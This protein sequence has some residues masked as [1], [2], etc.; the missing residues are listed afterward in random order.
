MPSFLTPDISGTRG[1]SRPSFC[2]FSIMA[3]LM[4]SSCNQNSSPQAAQPNLG[5]DPQESKRPIGRTTVNILRDI[6]NNNGGLIVPDHRALVVL[7][8]FKSDPPEWPIASPS[9]LLN[10]ISSSAL[11][12]RTA[13]PWGKHD[14][15]GWQTY[16]MGGAT[17]TPFFISSNAKGQC[18]TVATDNLLGPW[19]NMLS[20]V[21]HAE[22]KDVYAMFDLPS[23]LTPYLPRLAQALANQAS[24]DAQRRVV[25]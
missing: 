19:D 12:S 11:Y 22:D 10:D 5:T 4:T 13:S 2:M 23:A 21:V 25:Q 1:F 17:A 9:R 6:S 16:V 24:I 18:R 8:L 3:A 14:S 20:C 7:W 15:H